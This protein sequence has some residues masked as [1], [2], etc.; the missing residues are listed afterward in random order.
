MLA[1]RE[2]SEAQIRERLARREHDPTSINEAVARLQAV[3]ALDDRR[4]ALA[5]ARTEAH[6]RSRGRVRAMQRIRA[7]GVD[8]E[9]AEQA[10]D[11]V[12]GPL[13]E[14]ALVEHALARRLRGPSAR[15]LDASHFRRLYQQ[16]VRQGFSP[17]TV[18]AVLKTRARASVQ[19][20]EEG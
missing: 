6:I 9:L 5:C 8:A 4:V 13:D 14:V 7:M 17:S 2:L 20:D 1:R 11:E 3:G 15:I 18:M 19:E 10:V 16:L 12:F